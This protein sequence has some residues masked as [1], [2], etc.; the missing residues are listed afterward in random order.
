M[1]TQASQRA[2]QGRTLREI[3]NTSDLKP[4]LVIPVLQHRQLV[5]HMKQKFIQELKAPWQLWK[6]AGL[7]L[8]QN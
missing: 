1:I 8:E 5:L 2:L 6:G 3:S 7:E 4:Q